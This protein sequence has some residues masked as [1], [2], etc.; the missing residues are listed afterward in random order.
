MS[1]YQSLLTEPADIGQF[2][3][4]NA[5]DVG[6]AATAIGTAANSEAKKTVP[7]LV[8]N[9]DKAAADLKDKVDGDP[10]FQKAKE[11]S[12]GPHDLAAFWPKPPTEGNPKVP[13]AFSNDINKFL[14]HNG[15]PTTLGKEHNPIDVGEQIAQQIFSPVEK[16]VKKDEQTLKKLFEVKNEETGEVIKGGHLYYKVPLGKDGGD[17]AWH[18]HL[19]VFKE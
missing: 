3:H 13:S 17:D 19:R 4:K 1:P 9:V 14:A 7:D 6:N 12:S 10:D 16:T 18:S 11:S 5:E 2:V 8:Q 15:L